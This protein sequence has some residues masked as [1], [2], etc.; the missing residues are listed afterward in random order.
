MENWN[1]LKMTSSDTAASLYS[2]C[3][4]LFPCW[5]WNEA[6]LA[7]IV[8]DRS[9]DYEI[10]FAPNIEADEDFK[11][12]S[13]NDLKERG[14]QGITLPE[15]LKLELQYYKATGKHLDIDYFT[16]CAGSR[17]S[18]G[19]VP[20]VRCWSSDELGVGWD[21]PDVRNGVLRSRRAVS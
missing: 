6:K 19:S 4:K 16:L 5:C 7:N 9:G 21:D 8:S 17:Y 14:I 13:V 15:R 1:R 10:G 2:E 20:G 11:N 18:D 12:L 3:Q